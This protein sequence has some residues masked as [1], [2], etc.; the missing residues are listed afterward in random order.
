MSTYTKIL[1]GQSNY[2]TPVTK[3]SNNSTIDYYANDV[4]EEEIYNQSKPWDQYKGESPFYILEHRN[5]RIL[6]LGFDYRGKVL[7]RSL[8]K[9]IF[10]EKKREAILNKI[11]LV[12]DF[13]I[14]HVKS[15]KKAFN[16]KLEKKY[17]NFN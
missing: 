16:Y 10:I 3:G 15:I 9:I 13:M 11:E 12:I 5:D 17:R 1:E 4:D 8:A 7:K 2:L 6:H 14:D